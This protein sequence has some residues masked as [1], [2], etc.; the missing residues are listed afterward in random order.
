MFSF[1]ESNRKRHSQR[2]EVS[3]P[4]FIRDQESRETQ[5]GLELTAKNTSSCEEQNLESID[6]KEE[7]QEEKDFRSK[8]QRT[9]NTIK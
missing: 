2:V 7:N 6:L 9:V 8:G 5:D 4:L 1:Q 3:Q